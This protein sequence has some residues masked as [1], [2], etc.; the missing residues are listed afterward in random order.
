MLAFLAVF[1][2]VPVAPPTDA[3]VFVGVAGHRGAL[4]IVEVEGT[5]PALGPYATGGQALDL[6]TRD[7]TRSLELIDAAGLARGPAVAYAFGPMQLGQVLVHGPDGLALVLVEVDHRLPSVLDQD[8]HRL[9]SQLHSIVW[10]VEDLEAATAFLSGPAGLSL[11]ATF[12]LDAPEVSEFMLLPR[13]TPIRMSV[14]SASDAQA[15]RF[16]LLTYD[17]TAVRADEVGHRPGQPLAPGGLLPVFVTSDLEAAAGVL[18]GA[19]DADALGSK[20]VVVIPG[21][22][23]VE[24]RLD[25]AAAMGNV[26]P[27]YAAVP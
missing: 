5:T 9:H 10:S 12:P 8:T 23:D 7:M 25:P 4:R 11:R 17:R 6:Y 13:R 27:F 3:G 18:G 20:L 21:G 22:I 24:I 15:P 19:L 16:E 14:L 1:G 2:L 26:G